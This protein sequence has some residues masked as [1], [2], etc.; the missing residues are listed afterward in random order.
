MN[1]NVSPDTLEPERYEFYEE[2]RYRFDL[3]RRDFL[4]AVGGGIVVCL[5][6][7]DASALQPPERGRRRGFGAAMPQELGAWL[8]EGRLTFQETVVD[9]LENAPEALAR[10]MRGDTLGKTLVRIA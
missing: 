5:T 1:Q 2:P 10:V 7:R 6:L 3:D 9:G 4:K 8:Q